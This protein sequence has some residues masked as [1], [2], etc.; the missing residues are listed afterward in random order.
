[1]PKIIF[2]SIDI[3]KRSVEAIILCRMPFLMQPSPFPDLGLVP[4]MAP[5]TVEAEEQQTTDKSIQGQLPG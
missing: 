4:S 5:I 1:L 2:I 3:Q